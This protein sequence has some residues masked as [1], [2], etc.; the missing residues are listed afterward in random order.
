[1][2]PDEPT[3]NFEQALESLETIVC[4]LEDGQIGLAE[5]LAKYEL[6]IRYLKQ[7]YEILAHAERRIE[8]LSHVDPLSVAVTEVFDDSPTS[9][10]PTDEAAPAARSRRRS[11]P[12]PTAKGP[13]AEPKIPPEEPNA[14]D[15]PRSLF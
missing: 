1:V 11:R 7:C 14:M 15:L 12:S 9:C 8:M 3:P 6:G 2:T 4:E 13:T 10:E 5:S